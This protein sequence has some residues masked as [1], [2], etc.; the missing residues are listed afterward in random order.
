MGMGFMIG[1]MEQF[2]KETIFKTSE[3]DMES[4][5]KMV[6]KYMKENGKMENK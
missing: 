3:M 4:Y 2:T 5:M 6:K 1:E